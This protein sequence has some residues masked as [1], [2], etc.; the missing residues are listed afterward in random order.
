MGLLF[1]AAWLAAWTRAFIMSCGVYKGIISPTGKISYPHRN[2][3]THWGN[4]L[5]TEELQYS[6]HRE[7]IL[8]TQELFYPLGEYLIHAGTILPTKGTSYPRGWWTIQPTGVNHPT[9]ED[10]ELCYPRGY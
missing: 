2:Y 1:Y 9:H 3:P 4:I 10:G 7:N 5:S 6:T 8:S